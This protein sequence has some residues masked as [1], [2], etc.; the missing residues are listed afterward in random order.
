MRTMRIS[1]VALVAAGTLLSA[2][3]SPAAAANPL[4]GSAPILC[5][6]MQV[7][8]CDASGCERRTAEEVNLPPFFVVDIKQK[9]LTAVGGDGR[10]TPIDYSEFEKGKLVLHGGQE[11]R[12]WS[13]VVASDTGKLSASVVDAEATFVVSGA[14][15]LR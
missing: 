12:G 4:D 1:T 14:C 6:A 9:A 5:A 15:I 2:L 10:K 3:A 11:G 8:E 7:M 13:I